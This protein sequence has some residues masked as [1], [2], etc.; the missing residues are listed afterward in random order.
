MS[1]AGMVGERVKVHPMRG[2]EVADDGFGADGE[3]TVVNGHPAV[4]YVLVIG[5]DGRDRTAF[6]GDFIR[7]A[8]SKK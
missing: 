5:V 7:P 8:L 3:V 6:P 4:R 1:L 2:T